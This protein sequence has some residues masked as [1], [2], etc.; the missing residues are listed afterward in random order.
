M[1]AHIAKII[2]WIVCVFS[3]ERRAEWSS[4]EHL[5]RLRCPRGA[6]GFID[7]NKVVD[8]GVLNYDRARSLSSCFFWN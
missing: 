4:E 7:S 5:Y 6:A 2:G 1:V 3:H 8:N